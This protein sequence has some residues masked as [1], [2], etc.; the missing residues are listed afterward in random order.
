MKEIWG[1][2]SAGF[3]LGIPILSANPIAGVTVG[4]SF[5]VVGGLSAGV[6]CVFSSICAKTR[7]QEFQEKETLRL[8]VENDLREEKLRSRELHYGE[9]EKNKRGQE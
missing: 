2:V 3:L 7:K 4:T 9:E 1:S 5:A 6:H 8:K